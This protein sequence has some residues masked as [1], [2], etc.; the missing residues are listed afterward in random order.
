M[1]IDQVLGIQSTHWT[2]VQCI[3][4]A[5][6]CVMINTVRTNSGDN[7]LW[8]KKC[9]TDLFR[10]PNFN[11]WPSHDWQNGSKCFTL[12]WKDWDH[13]GYDAQFGWSYF[14]TLPVFCSGQNPECSICLESMPQPP[15]HVHIWDLLYLPTLCSNLPVLPK[16]KN[17][18]IIYCSS[19]KCKKLV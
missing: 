10:M 6:L 11:C 17:V 3:S 5:C 1:H 19:Q 12:V 2:E 18:W 4:Y 8:I 9:S 16:I 14:E 15:R 13:R 7:N